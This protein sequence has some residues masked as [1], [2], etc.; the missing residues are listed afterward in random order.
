[1]IHRVI[2]P[3][4]VALKRPGG[5]SEVAA[6]LPYAPLKGGHRLMGALPDSVRK[7]RLDK[8]RLVDLF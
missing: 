4:N 5:A 3:F 8:P 2:E 7:D 1:M 6:Y